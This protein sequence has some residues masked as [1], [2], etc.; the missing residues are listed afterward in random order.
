MPSRFAQNILFIV[1][2]AFAGQ[3]S[4]QSQLEKKKSA[5]PAASKAQRWDKEPDSFMGMRFGD[6]LAECP[7]AT[8]TVPASVRIEYDY[9]KIRESERPCYILTDSLSPP[10]EVHNLPDIGMPVRETWPHLIDGRFEG[11]HFKF[12]NRDY[13]RLKALFITRY[14]PPTSIST[15]TLKNRTGLSFDSPELTWQGRNVSIRLTEYG[16]QLDQGRVEVGTEALAARVRAKQ[17]REM[18]RVK[19]RL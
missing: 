5:R 6:P 7:R 13:D 17:E 11:F 10:G 15:V 4:A 1:A 12:W 8:T 18:E 2:I 9:P 3:S 14:G 19:G 16:D